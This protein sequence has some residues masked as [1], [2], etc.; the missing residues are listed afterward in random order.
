MATRIYKTPFA[1]T[2][3]KEALATADQPDGKVSLQAG[4]TP[5]Y[6]LPNDNANY[7][8]VGRAEMNGLL[9]ELTLA[10]GEMQLNGFAR[11]QSV[12]GG[13]PLNGQVLHNGIAYRST[14]DANLTEP[15]ATGATWVPMG[16]GIATAAQ[17]QALTD[18]SVL[19]TPKKLA[20]AFQGGNQSWIS[21]GGYQR[22]PGGFKICAGRGLT[23]PDGSL[24]IAFPDAFTFA[25]AVTLAAVDAGT[26]ANITLTGPPTAT[27]F[28]VRSAFTSNGAATS[29]NFYW[30]AMGI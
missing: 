4:W 26:S 20:S 22:L 30:M 27:G 18:D 17:A 5:D 3:D 19:L 9:N 6:E 14:A 16:S 24:V 23:P 12:D 28:P 15:G 2:G 8:P 10:L 1:A 25:P 13:W 7:R 21:G 29:I 11:W